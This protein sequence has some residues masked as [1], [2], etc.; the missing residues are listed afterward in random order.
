MRN[1]ENQEI[2]YKESTFQPKTLKTVGSWCQTQC[3]H[4]SI[5]HQTITRYTEYMHLQNMLQSLELFM[6]SVFPSTGVKSMYIN[7]VLLPF[8]C[9]VSS[10]F[11]GDIERRLRRRRNPQP[12]GPACYI[13]GIIF[14]HDQWSSSWLIQPW[15]QRL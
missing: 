9:Q 4:V 12:K 2:F 3:A 14:I 5:Y 1:C 11:S 6:C 13:F 15:R 8:V 7:S 10:V